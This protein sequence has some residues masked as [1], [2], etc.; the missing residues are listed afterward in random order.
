[1]AAL[2]GITFITFAVIGRVVLQYRSTGDH[3]V[4]FA[5]PR[6]DP[7]AA[8]AGAAFSLSFALS[9]LLIALDFTGTWPLARIEAAYHPHVATPVGFAGIAIVLIAQYQMRN[10]WRIG[11]DHGESTELVIHGLFARSR[12]PIY[13]GILLYWLGL[14]GTMP[15]PLIWGLGIVCWVSIEVIVREVEEPYLR[16]LHGASYSDY[17]DQTNR[18]LIWPLV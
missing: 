3:G 18:F 12:N 14:A 11:V 15:N 17:S 2:L 10:A 16:K 6:V 1:M 8:I 13:F 4:R 7:V 5:N 9:L